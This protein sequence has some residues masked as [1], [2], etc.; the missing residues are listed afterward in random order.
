MCANPVPPHEENAGRFAG[1]EWLSE[2][3]CNAIKY[4]ALG[5]TLQRL[6]KASTH[7]EFGYTFQKRVI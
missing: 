5:P 3:R 2:A 4:L 1:I 7:G 6:S